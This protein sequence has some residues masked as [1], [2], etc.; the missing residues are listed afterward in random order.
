LAELS[1]VAPLVRRALPAEGD[2]LTTLA[3]DG[4]NVWATDGR[5]RLVL[6]DRRGFVQAVSEPEVM[7]GVSTGS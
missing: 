6:L 4:V 2:S 7:Y 5:N 1:L 3:T